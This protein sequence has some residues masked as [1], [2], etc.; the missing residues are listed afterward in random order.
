[1]SRFA[2]TLDRQQFDRKP[3]SVAAITKRMQQG[4]SIELDESGFCEA[5]RRGQTWCGGCYEPSCDGWGAFVG[6]Q[7]VALDFDNSTDVLDAQGQTVRGADGR[8]AKRPLYP[9][10]AGFLSMTD[11]LDRCERLSLFPMCAY[12][13]MSA[14]DT[15]HKFRVVLDLGEHIGDEGEACAILGELLTAFPEADQACSN[16]NRLF[17]GSNGIVFECWR[18]ERP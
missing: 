11:A 18:D 3:Q 9:G 14:S 6:L 7:I 4:G 12:Q 5:V 15:W 10:E 8:K 1:M 13:T 17:F 2:V 16:L